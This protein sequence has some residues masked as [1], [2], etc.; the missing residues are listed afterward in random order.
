MTDHAEI[1]I[2]QSEASSEA[3]SS[4]RLR[5]LAQ[6]KDVLGAS[7]FGKLTKWRVVRLNKRIASAALL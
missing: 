4:D 3:T 7:H 2:L 6:Q 5:E 1:L